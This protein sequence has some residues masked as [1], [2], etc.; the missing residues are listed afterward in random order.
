MLV[1]NPDMQQICMNFYFKIP[2]AG[3]ETVDSIIFAKKDCIIELN[4]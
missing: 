4:F 1:D 3:E 2:K